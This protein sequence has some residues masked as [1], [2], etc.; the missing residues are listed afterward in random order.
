MAGANSIFYGDRLLTTD[1][2]AANQD[3]AL[4]AKLGI[5]PEKRQD[6][7]DEAHAGAIEQALQSAEGDQSF[8]TTP[9]PN[10]SLEQVLQSRLQGAQRPVT[11]TVNAR[12]HRGRNNLFCACRGRTTCLLLAM[13]T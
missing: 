2:P 3:R 9:E 7:S 8:Y 11:C 13:T 4:F 1:N 5:R 10:V 12:P 6:V